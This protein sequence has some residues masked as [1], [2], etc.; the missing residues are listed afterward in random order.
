MRDYQG[1]RTY[2]EL[3]LLIEELE[4]GPDL[5]AFDV[6]T[7]YLT[8]ESVE[9]R[10]LNT[11]NEDF[12]VVGFSIT[13]SS[14][15]ARYIPL[16]HDNDRPLDPKIV[17]E[18][19]RNIFET[20]TLIAHNAAF[21]RAA[22][23]SLY[24]AGDVERPLQMLKTGH[25]TMVMANTLGKYKEVGLKSLT[26]NVLGE[27]QTEFSALFGPEIRDKNG[28]VVAA[29]LKKVRFNSL[30]VTPE[31]INYG[32][33]DSAL[34]MELYER[35]SKEMT[36]A[37]KRV[38][39]V[40]MQILV[41]MSQAEEYGVGVDWASMQ[42]ALAQY[43]TFRPRFEK[44]VREEFA[45]MTVDPEVK[46]L[47]RTA[48]FG[49][50]VQMRKLL[51]NGLGMSTTRTTNK[52]E[53]STDAKALEALSRKHPAVRSLLSL[54]EIDN[55]GRRLKKWLKEYSDCYDKRVHPSFNQ[56]R[57]ISGR[58]AA[59]DPA[60][61]QLGK[62][63]L[64][65]VDGSVETDKEG[66][67]VTAEGVNGEDYW[68]GNFRKFI[69]SAPNKTLLTFD[70][71]VA[72]N[73]RILTSN[74]EWV[75]A[76]SIKVGDELV[77]FPERLHEYTRGVEK[78]AWERT[79]VVRVSYP[80]HPC[81][82][83]TL[84]DGR[85]VVSS[86]EHM[87]ATTGTTFSPKNSPE[88]IP[89]NGSSYRNQKTRKWVK[90]EDLVPGISKI[91]HAFTPW[92]NLQTIE[93]KT[94]YAYMA[95][96]MDG[97][98]WISNGRTIGFGQVDGLVW[99]KFNE[100][101]E[102]YNYKQ[103]AVGVN[104]VEG[105]KPVNRTYLSG[106]DSAIKFLALA[107][108]V[109]LFARQSDLWE[110]YRTWSHYSKPPTVVSVDFVGVQK[111]VSI[112]TE[113]H[114]F[115][116]EGLMSHNCQQEL[117][118]LTGITQEPTFA[119]AFA[120]GEDPHKATSAML[121]SKSPNTVT[122]EERQ[123]G[124]TINFALL[125][126]MGARA[127]SEQLAI[128]KEEAES[129]ID[130]YKSRLS[131]VGTW[132]AKSR[133]FGVTNGFVTSWFGRHMPLWAASNPDPYVRSGAERLAV[134][135]QIQGGAADYTKLA[136]I[137]A[138]GALKK[139][140]LWGNDKVMLTMNQHDSLTFEVSDDLDM[141]EIRGILQEAVVFDAR[142]MFPKMQIP[143]FPRFDVDWEL[144]KT[145]GGSVGWPLEVEA[146]RTESGWAIE[147]KEDSVDVREWDRVEEDTSISVQALE[148]PPETLHVIITAKEQ[149]KSAIIAFGQLVKSNPGD[150][151]VCLTMKGQTHKLGNTTSLSKK[152]ASRI[153]MALGG[154]EVV[155]RTQ[156]EMNE[157]L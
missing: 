90:T 105:R 60:I 33:D 147:G 106:R 46:E 41:L 104:A 37:Q 156:E 73:T 101:T 67:F 110:G 99:D 6:E 4:N 52:G 124:K 17:W 151:V 5:I 27:T 78:H 30:D 93:E 35:F 154:A 103:G 134:N 153:S 8:A 24:R 1:I 92:D 51:Y 83:I 9:K 63:W 137:R 84:S 13:N 42:E 114:T 28:K 49:S 152:D 72:P 100:F 123:I 126:G 81:Y 57:V 111:T 79:K 118:V 58:F 136:M 10:A 62:D 65:V 2:E 130:T 29:R 117:R 116:A 145:W 36:L 18:K 85:E 75:C 91:C 68:T 61:Q 120:N 21:E 47:A 107:R 64:W 15:W 53:L 16:R 14:Q 125:Y 113:S 22:L 7:G 135:A 141:N 102:K 139:A 86:A 40:E 80:S 82:K 140:G 131:N 119:N 44:K 149:N 155:E 89:Y 77:G 66:N 55:L 144:G 98:G 20:K 76:D 39:S 45:E 48:N 87:W 70:Y 143:V 142:Q 112:E 97:E 69:V 59:S 43:E 94:D 38:Y 108:P 122:K 96:L 150:T 121:F 26:T 95:G 88:Y 128:S 34:C 148:L 133:A 19:F 32:C 138:W 50:A 146:T 115:I 129:L 23:N 74:L 157:L 132:D 54:R 3:D 56:V 31:V 71:C 25:D 12:I 11:R 109:R 127:M